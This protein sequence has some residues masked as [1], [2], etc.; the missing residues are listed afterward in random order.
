MS[1]VEGM[2]NMLITIIRALLYT[3]LFM[4]LNSLPH[5]SP[6][7]SLVLPKSTLAFHKDTH[8]TNLVGSDPALCTEVCDEHLQQQ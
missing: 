7:H 6:Q 5:G 3:M 8:E 4:V 1:L 2:L